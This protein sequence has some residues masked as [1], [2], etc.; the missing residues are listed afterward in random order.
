MCVGGYRVNEHGTSTGYFSNS[1]PAQNLLSCTER[2]AVSSV[3]KRKIR[4]L[5]HDIRLLMH[6]QI[7]N[8]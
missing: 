3:D 1:P 4:A 8:A 7:T 6:D 5:M 2:Q